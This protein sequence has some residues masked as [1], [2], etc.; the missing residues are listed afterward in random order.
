MTE[1]GA[2]FNTRGRSDR[3]VSLLE[4]AL[5]IRLKDYGPEHTLVAVT[6]TEL[7]DAYLR[8]GDLDAAA[9]HLDASA[10][11]LAEAPGRRSD[12]LRATLERL[13]TARV[14]ASAANQD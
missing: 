6:R 9:V 3:A 11:V 12:R 14:A 13:E 8:L 1:L 2:V 4:D 7:G 10:A 5:E